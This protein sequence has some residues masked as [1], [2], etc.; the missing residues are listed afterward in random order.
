VIRETLARWL[1]GFCRTL[2]NGFG[3]A[4]RIIRLKGWTTT[5]AEI[6]TLIVGDLD[7][8]RSR[9]RSLARENP[10]ASGA[11]SSI[12]SNTIG[13][14]IQPHS[15]HPNP[16]MRA[17]INLLFKQWAPQSDA[18]GQ[19]DFY[20]Q[21]A[22]ICR[23]MRTDGE[24]FVRAR[25]RRPSDRLVVPLQ[26]Q[27]IEADHCPVSQN[28]VTS[29]TPI[30][31]GVKFDPIGRRISYF[32]YQN[33]PGGAGF[34]RDTTLHEIPASQVLHPYEIR[35]PGQLRG[36]PWLT[37]AIVM[38]Y[39]IKQLF[40]AALLRAKIANLLSVFIEKGPTGGDILPQ[41]GEDVPMSQTD[42]TPQEGSIETVVRPGTVNYLRAGEKVV[43]MNPNTGG[44]EFGPFLSN[45]LHAVARALDITYE[46]LT[47][48]LSGVNYSSIRAGVLEFRRGCEQ[49][50]Y[51]VMIQMFCR[52]VWRWFIEQAI[53][54]GALGTEAASAF[55]TDP[56]PFL[57]VR[58]DPPGWPWVDPL[59]DGM[60][61]R[62]AVRDG[63]STR[64]RVCGEMGWDSEEI[65]AENA[66]DNER[67][68][69]SHLIY[70]SDGR[71]AEGKGDQKALEVL[72]QETIAANAA[73]AP[74]AGGK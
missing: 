2:A 11:I 23:A 1:L 45:M 70:D 54:S 40:D 10:W 74:P 7:L 37:P 24:V 19:L 47:G 39:D 60:A 4:V 30:R 68:D 27:L 20:G 15:R 57:D 13:T 25:F 14:G 12:V 41:T 17:R 66:L 48:D 51:H 65:D 56:A 9:S 21:Q 72:K 6:N 50:Q 44:I 53:L 16:E 43:V 28:D 33:H 69:A 58:W 61:M 42:S 26:L 32:L 52:P 22:L 3:A 31:C 59:K 63:F 38:L 5:N 71:I 64:S 29:D 35:R 55:A 73:S 36:T 34:M 49:F 8:M 18:A 67:A 46:M 62:A